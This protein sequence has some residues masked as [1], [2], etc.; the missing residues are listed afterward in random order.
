MSDERILIVDDNRELLALLSQDVLPR[1]GYE[2]LCAD[3]GR[4]ALRLIAQ[5]HPDLILLDI[6]MPDISGIDVLQEMQWQELKVPVVLMTA[7]GS[8]SIAVD[9]FRLGVKDYLIKPFDM[10][11]LIAVIDRQLSQIRFEREKERLNRELAQARQDLEQRVK[12]LTVL[13]GISKSVTSLLDLDRVLERVVEAAAFIAKAEEG[14]LWLLEPNRDQLLLRAKK[15]LGHKQALLLRLRIRDTLIGQVFQHSKPIRLSSDSDQDGM[16]IKT[17][18]LVRALLAVP[19]ITKGRTVGVLSVA[20]RTHHRPFTASNEA[21][22]QALAEY[23]AIA[24]ENARVYQA[25]D[26][27]LAQRVNELT[28]LYDIA[29]TVTST[30]DEQKVFNLV[31]ARISDMF[32]VEA[33]SLLLLDKETQ[34]LEFVTTWLGDREPPRGLRLK[35]GQ[36]I[37][38]EAALTRQPIMVNNAYDDDRFFAEVDHQTGFETRSI[39]CAPL[40]IHDRCIGVIELLN[41]TDGPFTQGDMERLGNVA[42][43]ISIALENARLFSEA[44]ELH[45]AKSR[46]VATMARELRSPLTAIKGYSSMLLSGA[47]GPLKEKQVESIHQIEASTDRLITLMEDLLDIARLETGESHLLFQPVSLKEVITP[48][49]SSWE[50]RLKDKNLRLAVKISSRLPP[51]Y[52]DRERLGQVLNSLLMNAYLYTLPKGRI[53]LDAELQG[54]SRQ[55]HRATEWLI[56]SVAD[57]GIGI[58]PPDQTRVFERFFRGDHPLVRQHSGRGLSLSIAKSLVELHGGRIWV[59]SQTGKGSIFRFTLPLSQEKQ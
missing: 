19:L 56:V 22:L 47:V 38:G 27:A 48:I 57:T 31:A 29:R 3:G 58:E 2:A 25:T 35:L 44:R 39:L 50:Q 7:H 43:S 30:L 20:N 51:V 37:A 9:A 4:E 53:T 17:D 42:R 49:V 18:Y 41:K 28:Y 10:N 45:E 46:F 54:G 34:E 1:Y 23:A 40:L 13:F 5:E 6:Q 52:A 16:K 33:G 15:G 32:Q 36:G 11:L 59:E 55:E 14:A 12:E 26:Q 8:E 21:T 24:I